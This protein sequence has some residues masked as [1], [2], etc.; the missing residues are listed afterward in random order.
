ME[1]ASITAYKIVTMFIMALVGAVCYKTR[2]ISSETNG[3]LSDLLLMVIAPLMIFC[4]Y[5]REFSR[6]QLEGLLMTLFLAAVSHVVAILVTRVFLR[7]KS[8]DNYGIECMAAVYSNCGFMGIPLVNGIFGADGVFY[9]TAYI[10]IF[11]LFIWT[12]GILMMIGKQSFRDAVNAM[13][14]PTIGAILA[15][16]IC[17]L[18]QIRIPEV[19]REPLAAIGDMNTPVAML[20][21]GASLASSNL[22][23]MLKK[24]RIY[25]ICFL[26]LLL[27]P[28]VCMVV[29]N[30]FRLD[31]VVTTT[32]VLASA[33]P[34]ASTGTMF[35]LRYQKDAVYAA[36]MFGVTTALSIITIPFVMLVYTLI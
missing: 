9:I 24:K 21:A 11:N 30:L 22:F 16:L 25:L 15:G 5:Q 19:I 17:Y 20:V 32:V 27:I 35:A 23:Q 13:K 34:A 8:G 2:I 4:S 29:L 12:H 36:E 6:Q 18:L 31:P 26:R 28:L 14:T 7:K 33:C 10:T 3:K 1:L